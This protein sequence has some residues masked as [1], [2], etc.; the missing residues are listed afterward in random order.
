MVV[1]CVF[2]RGMQYFAVG[3]HLRNIEAG[4]LSGAE[5]EDDLCAGIGIDDVSILIEQDD[6]GRQMFE[7][8]K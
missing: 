5:R 8:C 6:G 7:S 4:D 1:D 2:Q 3:E